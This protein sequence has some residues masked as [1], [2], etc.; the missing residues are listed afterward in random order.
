M[1]RH[2]ANLPLNIMLR[3]AQKAGQAA[4]ANAVCAGRVVAGWKD[5]KL[6]EYGP[7]ALPLSQIVRDEE[8]H[9]VRA[10]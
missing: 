3:A 5:G 7:G 6:V 2:V 8:S 9:H 10:A 1:K 4:A